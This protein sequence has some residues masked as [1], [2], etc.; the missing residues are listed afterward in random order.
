LEKTVLLGD[1]FTWYARTLACITY[2]SQEHQ[3]TKLTNINFVDCVVAVAC[4]PLLLVNST[5]L[6]TLAT[7]EG[8]LRRF[9]EET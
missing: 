7:A 4:A 8:K 6:H 1:S 2:A 5:L 3:A 9:F